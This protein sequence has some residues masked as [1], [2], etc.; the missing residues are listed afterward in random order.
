MI[1]YRFFKLLKEKRTSI[2]I[3]H[4]NFNLK[5]RDHP[6]QEKTFIT[7]VNDLTENIKKAKEYVTKTQPSGGGDFPEAVCCGLHDCCEKLK[8]REDAIKVAILIADAPPHG[9]GNSYWI[10]YYKQF[11]VLVFTK[12]KRS[13]G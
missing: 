13:D 8:W 7:Q 6:P 4:I 1:R 5:N 10:K 12:I 11:F 3:T 2:S 9:M